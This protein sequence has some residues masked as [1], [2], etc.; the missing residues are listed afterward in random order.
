MAETNYLNCRRP[1]LKEKAVIEQFKICS[2]LSYLPLVD[3]RH[4]KMLLLCELLELR[5]LD[6]GSLSKMDP[7]ETL[8]CGSLRASLALAIICIASYEVRS[9]APFF[10]DLAY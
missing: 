3:L 7:R 10:S 2:G 9:V 5:L 1:V 8:F 6:D 4:L